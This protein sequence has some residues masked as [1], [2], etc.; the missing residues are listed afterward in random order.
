MKTRGGGARSNGLRTRL[1]AG[2]MAVA[3]AAAVA[4][5]A[6]SA[7][8]AT[9]TPSPPSTA[10]TTGPATTPSNAV[11]TAQPADEILRTDRFRRLAAE[12]RCLVCQNQSLADSNAELA[13]DLRDEVV[14]LMQTGMDD[15]Q[16]KRHLVDRY[17]DFVLYRPT[18][19]PRNW[20]LWAGPFVMLAIGALVVWRIGRRR[21]APQ[22]LS[23]E[24]TERIRRLL[25][26]PS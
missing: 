25:D 12:L 18:L 15:A 17:G 21:A 24:E 3:V 22:P 11:I 19:Q 10:L 8:V 20:A 6:A 16:I 4:A 23:R 5:G 14:R 13:V 26:D 2:A 1:A 7:Q 9:G